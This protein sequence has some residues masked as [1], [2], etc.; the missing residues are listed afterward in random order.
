MFDITMSV[1]ESLKSQS[2]FGKE[3]K[4]WWYHTTSN[5]LSLINWIK[6]HVITLV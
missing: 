2:M 1:L 3:K 6:T 4:T 5:H